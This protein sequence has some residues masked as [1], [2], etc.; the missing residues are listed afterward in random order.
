MAPSN[1]ISLNILSSHCWIDSSSN[2]NPC[3]SEQIVQ[4]AD[5]GEITLKQIPPMKRRRLNKLSKMAMHSSYECLNKAAVS[6]DATI[7]IFASQH[8]ELERTI[9]IVNSMAS[10]QEISP[11]DFSLSV[12]NCSLG[13]FSIFT[14]NKH[15]GTSI[16]AGTNSFGFALLESYNYLQRFPQEKVLL[17]CFDLEVT[18]PFDQF[19][20]ATFPSYSISLLLTTEQDEGQHL[21]FNFNQLDELKVPELP[22]ALRF[23][24]FLFNDH[25]HSSVITN[26]KI[27][28]FSKSAV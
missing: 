2:S 24:E 5:F 14:N 3:F 7:N 8:G 13:L 27:W 21:S 9:K 20:Q 18:Q 12:H 19:Q 1:P 23:F 26:S 11:K 22:L 17:T 6:P 10:E 28:E 15:P 4:Q 16:A 25:N